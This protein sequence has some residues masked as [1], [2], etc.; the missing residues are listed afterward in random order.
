MEL[1]FHP[2]TAGRWED[3]VS[4]FGERGACGGCWC[5]V[6]RLPRRV[7]EDGKGDG[8]R[9]RLKELVLHD[10]SPGVI[11]YV[12]DEPVGWCALAPREDYDHL[13]R[14][15]VLKPVDDEAVWSISCL[16]VKRGL[17]RQGVSS[18]L[19]EA[20]VDMAPLI[21]MTFLLLIFFL[22]NTNF[23][24]ETGIEVKRPSAGSG[25]DQGKDII[26]VGISAA[27][28]SPPSAMLP[29]SSPTVP[30]ESARWRSRSRLMDPDGWWP[31]ATRH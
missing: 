16:F 9:E 22:V 6:W 25:T 28:T 11:G 13:S 12:N 1:L 29:N 15:R 10:L 26:L 21:D 30:A 24:K 19:L 31:H 5:M 4:L 18:R 2:L 7:Y 3:F 20:A 27:G 8:N 14:S 17:R 23:I